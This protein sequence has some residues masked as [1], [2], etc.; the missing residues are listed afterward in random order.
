VAEEPAPRELT[1]DEARAALPAA[2][3]AL[4]RLQALQGRLR[5]LR[6]ALRALAA[7][8]RGNGV[9]REERLRSL[10]REQ[11]SHAALASSALDAVRAT[12]AELRAI[13]P[14]LLDFPA[15]V[16]GQPAYWC[17][18]DGEADLAWWHTREDGFAGRRPIA[19]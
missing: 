8:H 19:G 12:G 2:R 9:P 5:E 4:E 7:S 10:R 1:L 6:G 3:A 11:A 15:R 17:W 16:E 13:D 14:G 18:R